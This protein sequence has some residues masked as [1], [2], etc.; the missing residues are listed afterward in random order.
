M[1]NKKNKAQLQKEIR[2]MHEH[3]ALG[4]LAVSTSLGVFALSTEAR[5]V[6]TGLAVRPA[7]AVV[8]HSMDQCETARHLVELDNQM[9]APHMSGA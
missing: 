5:Q 8:K 7:Y 6:M 2:R 4:V 3:V 1:Q 9:R